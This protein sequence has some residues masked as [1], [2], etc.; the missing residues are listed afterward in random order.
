MCTVPDDDDVLL[1]RVERV[2]V[3]DADAVE[4]GLCSRDASPDARDAGIDT[5]TKS[6]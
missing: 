4:G 5:C 1:G 6:D 2:G 3:L